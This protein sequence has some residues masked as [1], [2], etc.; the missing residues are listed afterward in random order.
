MEVCNSFLLLYFCCSCFDFHF[1]DF[2]DAKKIQKNRAFSSDYIVHYK[3]VTFM[4][5]MQVY[6][7][8]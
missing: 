8:C 7:A 5:R 2:E 1:K 6:Q 3:G 4:E